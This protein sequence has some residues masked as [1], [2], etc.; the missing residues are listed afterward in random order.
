[1]P[2]AKFANYFLRLCVVSVSTGG[3][4]GWDRVVKGG[5]LTDIRMDDGIGRAN[6]HCLT[7]ASFGVVDQK[8]IV[9]VLEPWPQSQLLITTP[10]PPR[11]H[12]QLKPGRVKASG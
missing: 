8:R 1:M 5:A 3:R 7:R 6:S 12:L 2:K 10:K 9:R 11:Y 4:C